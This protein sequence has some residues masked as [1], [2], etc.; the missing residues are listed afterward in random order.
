MDI[1]AL[2]PTFRKGK[3]L[4]VDEVVLSTVTTDLPTQSGAYDQ[5]C[6][7]LTGLQLVD[8][9]FGKPGH[10]DILLGEDVFSQSVCHGQRYR[11]IQSPTVFSTRFG[12][13]LAGRVGGNHQQREETS[14]SSSTTS[15][16]SLLKK[17]WEVF[18]TPYL[19]IEERAVMEHLKGHHY[20]D[21]SGRFVV[22]FPRRPPMAPLGNLG[23]SL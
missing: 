10:I 9:D 11:P 17:V 23:L 12:W 15:C 7:P 6:R 22:P 1:S 18:S 16:H 21:D 19:F 20:K 14:C 13:V 3:A 8:L 2:S 4:L 5:Q